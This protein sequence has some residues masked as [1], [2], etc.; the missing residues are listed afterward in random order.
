MISIHMVLYKSSVTQRGDPESAAIWQLS[1]LDQES[2]SRGM[3]D[4]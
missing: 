3:H 2:A 4:R 1:A